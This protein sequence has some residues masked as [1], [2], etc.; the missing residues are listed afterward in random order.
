MFFY[1]IF[2]CVNM[3][4]LYICM[5]DMTPGVKTNWESENKS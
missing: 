1:N 5:Y 2:V 4:M 3:Y